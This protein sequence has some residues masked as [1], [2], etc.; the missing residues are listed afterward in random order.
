MAQPVI[1]MGTLQLYKT[2]CLL[3]HQRN[4][5]VLFNIALSSVYRM[6]SLNILNRPLE[7]ATFNKTIHNK[8]RFPMD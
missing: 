6:S 8:T 2:Q 1:F 5:K 3:N 4:I 7:T